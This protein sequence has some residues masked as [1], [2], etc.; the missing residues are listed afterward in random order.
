MKTQ[1]DQTLAQYSALKAQY[2]RIGG[3]EKNKNAMRGAQEYITPPGSFSS[4]Q[5]THFHS[6][7]PVW[8]G[9]E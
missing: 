7:S 1:Y 3:E 5:K 4:P 6:L 8:G 2:D 9:G